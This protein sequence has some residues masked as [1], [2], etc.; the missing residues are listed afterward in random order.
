MSYNKGKM[1]QSEELIVLRTE[2][3][4]TKQKTNKQIIPKKDLFLLFGF[5]SGCIWGI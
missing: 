3:R 5:F 4:E 1:F 2:F